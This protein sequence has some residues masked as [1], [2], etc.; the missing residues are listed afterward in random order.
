[1]HAPTPQAAQATAADGRLAPL[2]VS[3]FFTWGFATVL[4]DTLIPRLKALFELTYAEAMLTQFAF[5]LGYLVFSW[6][7]SLLL[8]RIG[9]LRQIV[10]GLCVM[11]AGC[12]LFVP[13]GRLG[14][15]PA[16]LFALFVMAAGITTLQVAA[17]PLIALLGPAQTSHARLNLAQ[18]FNSLGTTVGPLVGAALMLS[19]GASASAAS[20]P[21]VLVGAGL[22]VLA[23]LF[24]TVRRSTAAPPA[25]VASG[26]DLGLLR[27]PRLA[28]G[29]AAIFLYVG[30]EVAIGSL[31]VSYL[32]QS[33]VLDA[34]AAE[35]GRLV[36]AYWGAAMFGRFVG[37]VALRRVSAG[38]ALCACA[39][40]AGLLASAAAAGAGQPAAFAILAIGLC[41]SIMFPTIFTLAIEGLGERTPQGS[42]LLCLAIVGG[43]IVPVATGR[44]A[45]LIGL[46]LSLLVP[47]I[48]YGGIAA[49]GWLAWRTSR[50]ERG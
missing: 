16:F 17:N 23:L 47:A 22:G 10:V 41:N 20:L 14:G 12:L 13:A 2:V 44:I 5:F 36:A 8:G 6:P 18:A 1:M 7:A 49:Y 9:Y 40:G 45:D 33:H 31:L 43:A 34:P 24:W 15:Y 37:A 42:G 50:G 46:S 4:I 39:L 11:G 26:L 25:S 48:C 3:L 27:R 19:A 28:L 35:A 30:A 38:L 32:M 21:F 29:V